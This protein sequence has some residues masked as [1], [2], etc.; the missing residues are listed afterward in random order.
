M[1]TFLPVKRLEFQKTLQRATLPSDKLE[2]V[3]LH[4]PKNISS[5]HSEIVD[6][7]RRPIELQSAWIFPS[8]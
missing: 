6:K 1:F 3:R 8:D 7:P 5:S 2:S 4:A